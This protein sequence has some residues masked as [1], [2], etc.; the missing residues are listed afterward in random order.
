VLGP[1]FRLYFGPIDGFYREKFEELLASGK[2][3]EKE[4]FPFVT[5]LKKRVRNLRKN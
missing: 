4:D 5:E 1:S 2:L 3:K